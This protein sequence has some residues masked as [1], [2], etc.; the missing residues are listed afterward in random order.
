VFTISL[1]AASP[2]PVTLYWSTADGTAIGGNNKNSDYRT[3]S[4]TLTFNPGQTSLT[5]TVRVTGD[6]KSEPNETFSV[7]LAGADNATIADA[8]GVGTILNDDGG[9]FGGANSAFLLTPK[10]MNRVFAGGQGDVGPFDWIVTTSSTKIARR[11]A[12]LA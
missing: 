1:S 4:G 10:L 8:Q 2:V 12:G 11:V 7:N 3:G 6:R 5:V 9:S